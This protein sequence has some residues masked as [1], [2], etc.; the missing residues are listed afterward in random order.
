M[1]KKIEITKLAFL[2]S[3]LSFLALP[4]VDLMAK[5]LLLDG[6]TVFQIALG[7]FLAHSVIMTVA[8]LFLKHPFIHIFNQHK[9]YKIGISLGSVLLT[10]GFYQALSSMPIT[11][12]IT[13]FFLSPSLVSLFSIIFLKEKVFVSQTIAIVFGFV[14]VLIIVRPDVHQ[15]NEGTL[16]GLLAALGWSIMIIIKNLGKEKLDGLQVQCFLG[17]FNVLIYL[18]IV[19]FKFRNNS[20]LESVN[21]LLI[22]TGMGFLGAVSY[23]SLHFANKKINASLVAPLQYLE[24]VSAILLDYIFFHILPD[25]IIFLGILFIFFSGWL[26]YRCFKNRFH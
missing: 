2:V 9:R 25:L 14:G 7:R 5:T 10:L 18:P 1:F 24:I 11:N 15:F 12:A 8:F 3:I 23:L 17:I 6:F 13:I 26:N 21:F 4:I 19:L 22:T 16:Y 20:M